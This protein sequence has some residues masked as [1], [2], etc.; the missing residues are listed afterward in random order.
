VQFTPCA[1]LH[2]MIMAKMIKATPALTAYAARITD[3]LSFHKMMA[4]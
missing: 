1:G 3:R 4:T 2:F